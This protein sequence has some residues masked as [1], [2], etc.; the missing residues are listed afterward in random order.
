MS[1]KNVTD[2]ELLTFIWGHGLFHQLWDKCHGQEARLGTTSLG[3][4]CRLRLGGW[5]RGQRKCAPLQSDT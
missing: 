5:E 1:L 2:A 3:R 4:V